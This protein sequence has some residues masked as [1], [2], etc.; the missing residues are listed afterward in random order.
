M[1]SNN[2]LLARHSLQET[3]IVWPEG[4]HY[5]LTAFVLQRNRA[6][7]INSAN[8]VRIQGDSELFKWKGTKYFENTLATA[9]HYHKLYSILT[10]NSFRN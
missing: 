3:Q 6:C 4:E 2:E 7:A 10:A 5:W 8:L 1:V 9:N